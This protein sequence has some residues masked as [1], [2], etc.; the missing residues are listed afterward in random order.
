[1]SVAGIFRHFLAMAVTLTRLCN[2]LGISS[3]PTC[4]D[5]IPLVHVLSFGT[6]ATVQALL[7]CARPHT[8]ATTCVLASLL[9]G[10]SNRVFGTSLASEGATEVFD[11]DEILLYGRVSKSESDGSRR[12]YLQGCIRRTRFGVSGLTLRFSILNEESG[13]NSPRVCPEVTVATQAE[14]VAKFWLHD[15]LTNHRCSRDQTRDPLLLSR[16]IDVGGV[17]EGREPFLVC[18]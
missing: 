8:K 5:Q 2:I 11:C 15:C 7:T 3:G 4:P 13:H 10:R 9:V 16:V 17:E 14:A 18:N 6:E 12:R 1:M